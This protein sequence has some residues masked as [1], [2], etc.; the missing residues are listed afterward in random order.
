MGNTHPSKDKIVHP[1]MDILTA[2]LINDLASGTEMSPE[3]LRQLDEKALKRKYGQE[4]DLPNKTAAQL[5]FQGRNR[6]A[7][8]NDELEALLKKPSEEEEFSDPRKVKEYLDK[9]V[10]GQEE[11]KRAFSVVLVDYLQRGKRTGLLLLGPS[12]S[13]KTYIPQLIARKLKIPF[14]KKSLANMSSTGFKGQ[15]LAEGLEDLVGVDRGILFLDEMDKIAEQPEFGG[16]GSTLQNE[17]LAIFTGE[18]IKMEIAPRVPADSPEEDDDEA[19]LDQQPATGNLPVTGRNRKSVV[20]YSYGQIAMGAVDEGQVRQYL[21]ALV[22]HLQREGYTTDYKDLSSGFEDIPPD[23]KKIINQGG[24]R[25]VRA[26]ANDPREFTQL[27]EEYGIQ[28]IVNVAG[29]YYVNPKKEELDRGIKEGVRKKDRD[30]EQL[31]RLLNEEIEEEK[32]REE[33]GNPKDR[34]QEKPK[35]KEPTNI[36]DTSKILV[37]CAGAFH[38]TKSSPSLYKIVQKRLGGDTCTLDETELL[39]SMEDNDLM[40]Y[41]FKPE[42]V[43]RINARA[44]LKPLSVD[45]F[46]QILKYKEESPLDNLRTY[47]EELGITLRFDDPC[48]LLL[49]EYAHEGI[50]VRGI[51]K[52]LHELTTDLSF[53]RTDHAGRTFAFS[54]SGLEKKLKK[55]VQ[56]VKI[57][58]Y[59]VDWLNINSIIGYLDLFVPE[60]QE[61]KVEL[62]KAFH[63]YHLRR[64]PKNERLKLPLANMIIVG[65]SGSGKTYMVDLLARKAQLPIARTTATGKVPEG[66]S[67]TPLAEVFER[68]TEKQKYGIVH[69]DEADKVLLDIQN[70][71]NNELI[72][73]IEKG[74][75]RGRRTDNY[76]FILSGAFQDVYNLK[77]MHGLER[78]ITKDDLLHL[79]IREELVGRLP[80]LVNLTPPTLQTMLAVLQGPDSVLSEYANYFAT[81]EYSLEMEPGVLELI[82]SK[83][84]V[85]PLGFRE[86]KSISG[87]LFN[88]YMVNFAQY[89]NERTKAVYV[90]LDDAINIL[91]SQKKDLPEEKDKPSNRAELVDLSPPPGVPSSVAKAYEEYVNGL[92]SPK[93][94]N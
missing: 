20:I 69:I 41:G 8:I 31:A 38:G 58:Q 50:G 19:A 87:T 3:Q 37:I 15:N 45:N 7:E 22:T 27:L 43:G 21:Q 26:R 51:E 52:L 84:L 56:F 12:G 82:A 74:E 44:V 53:D 57:N 65:P 35:P 71:L 28:F 25:R 33:N 67:G 60:Q 49:A 92:V 32:G 91:G 72:G 29:K 47:F 10:E 68:F 23:V 2:R 70:P 24:F 5:L 85:L 46:Y 79:G 81:R 36:V 14:V 11:A 76:L 4:K 77:K 86:L 94:K 88:E 30:D 1:T 40:E 42:L 73:F 64:D 63:L 89:A 48:L 78:H 62:A 61:A 9:Y 13:G 90:K 18:K 83:A 6:M 17:L 54:R 55:H 59:E 16:F 34:Q 80:I 39:R 75:V 93:Q 66:F